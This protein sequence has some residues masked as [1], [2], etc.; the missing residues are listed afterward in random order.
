MSSYLGHV[1]AVAAVGFESTA[2]LLYVTN[3]YAMQ[4]IF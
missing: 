4:L 1:I 3:C 2:A